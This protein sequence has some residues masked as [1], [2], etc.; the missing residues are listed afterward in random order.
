MLLDRRKV[1]LWQK[2]V[3]SLM[4]FLLAGSLVWGLFQGCG[5]SDEGASAM[6]Q[7]DSEIEAQD[8]AVTAAPDDAAAWTRLGELYTER[9]NMQV[10]GSDGQLADWDEA[11]TAYTHADGLLAEEKGKQAKQARLDVLRS[12]ADVQL[13]LQDYQGATATYGIITQIKPKDAQAY[14]EMAS[15]A[16]NAGDHKTALLA[17][18]RFLELDPDSPDAPA[19]KEWI[20]LN[21]PASGQ[22]PAESPVE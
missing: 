22:E 21:T 1:K 3:F 11:I 9:G 4:A 8:A 19:V 12:L 18:A 6:E 15:I 10:E 20:E 7:V 17:F 2:I 14:F 5:G 16:I 13:F